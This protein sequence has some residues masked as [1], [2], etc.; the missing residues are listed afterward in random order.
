MDE[1]LLYV[2]PFERMNC[3]S[4]I[5]FLPLMGRLGFS[6]CIVVLLI[7]SLEN[8]CY[9]LTDEF[10]WFLKFLTSHVRAGFGCMQVNSPS[11]RG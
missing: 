6:S 8:F 4:E 2:S 1:H 7:L 3:L 11:A 5:P 10:P 9:F